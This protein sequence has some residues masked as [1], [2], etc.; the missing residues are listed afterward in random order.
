MNNNAGIKGYREGQELRYTGK[1]FL[2]FDPSDTKM[3]F[4]QTYGNYDIWVRYKGHEMTVRKHEVVDPEGEPKLYLFEQAKSNTYGF[5]GS[6][7]LKGVAICK[8][9]KEVFYMNSK[10]APVN[11]E[12]INFIKEMQNGGNRK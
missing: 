9:Y 1:G 6:V 12:L 5:L 4:I 10:T 7:Y 3:Y 11:D 8:V 2:G